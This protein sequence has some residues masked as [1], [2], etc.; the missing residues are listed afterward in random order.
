M[1]IIVAGFFTSRS[2]TY[3]HYNV[4]FSGFVCENKSNLQCDNGKCVS[5]DLVCDGDNACGDKSD[6]K[7]C[8]CLPT[9]FECSTGECLGVEELCDL[10]KDCKD[11]TDEARCGKQQTQ[12][13]LI[14]PR[15]QICY[16][17]VS[18]I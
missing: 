9:E 3:C 7:N 6:E 11:G 13:K 10:R 4:I 12:Q 5:K 18:L 1:Q 16:F 17:R 15:N 8:K 14:I 2:F